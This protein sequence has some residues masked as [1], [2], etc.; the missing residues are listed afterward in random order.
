MQALNAL[1]EALRPK[2]EQVA[3]EGEGG[4]S[5]ASA[6]PPLVDKATLLAKLLSGGKNAKFTCVWLAFFFFIP[7]GHSIVRFLFVRENRLFCSD[8]FLLFHN[9][10]VNSYIDQRKS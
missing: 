9:V 4:S 8:I 6:S 3:E 2:A 7:Q 10:Q 5:S 1:A